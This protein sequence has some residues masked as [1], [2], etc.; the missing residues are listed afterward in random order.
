MLIKFACPHCKV[1]L[2]VGSDF[3]GK[4]GNCPNCKKELTVPEKSEVAQNEA[5]KTAKK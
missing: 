1:A 2:N 3:A 4:K 5:E